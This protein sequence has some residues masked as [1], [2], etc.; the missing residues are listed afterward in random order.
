MFITI[1]NGIDNVQIV[2]KPDADK[3]IEQLLKFFKNAV[4]KDYVST[5]EPSSEIFDLAQ[6]I[7]NAPEVK[8]FLTRVNIFLLT[9]GELKTEFKTSEKIAGY[10]IYYRAIGINYIFSI[11]LKNQEFRLK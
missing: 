7:A 3:A 5:V 9:D 4:Y 6:T 1:Y 2:S 8:E 10:T 11:F